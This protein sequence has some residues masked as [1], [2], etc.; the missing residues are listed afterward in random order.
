[1]AT[2][3]LIDTMNLFMRVK[4]ISRRGTIDVRIGMVLHIMLSSLNKSW[5][6]F[7]ADHVVFCLEGKDN[8]RKTAYTP[9]K[10]NRKLTMAKRTQ[11][12]VED[13]ELFF[14]AFGDFTDYLRNKTNCSVLQCDRVEA[15]D[16]IATWVQEHPDDRNIIVSTDSD[17]VQLLADNVEIFNGVTDMH[18]TQNAVY[19][20]K[21]ENM[22]FIVESSGKIKIS[23]PEPDFVPEDDWTKFQ[24]FL[25]CVRGDTSDNVF[26]A[27][28]GARLKG[29]SNKVGIREAF[30]D[31]E[32][33]G[34]HYNN[35]MLQTWTDHNDETHR[36][37]DKY[38]EN[39]SIIDLTAQP[40]EIKEICRE[41]VKTV[42][43]SKH[44]PMVGIHFMKF[45]G[46]WGLTRLSQAPD[47]FAK[48]L[49]NSIDNIRRDS[50]VDS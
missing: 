11:T 13:D 3:L 20:D 37:K 36:V 40:E 27:F 48:I 23:N 16:L 21:G 6:K 47:D 32:G 5:K 1:M 10:A 25:K 8:W 14:E 30:E 26:P 44:I 42:I 34:F 31:R 4:N 43:N 15:D 7:D 9:Y 45:C 39:K 22:K 17:F 29:S 28:P 2:Y 19:N 41:A 46:K 33:M 24:L 12:E 35:F 49:N 18:L 50:V 38:A